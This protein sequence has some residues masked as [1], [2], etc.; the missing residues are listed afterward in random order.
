MSGRVGQSVSSSLSVVE[1]APD[2]DR[3]TSLNRT[4][5]AA[6]IVHHSPTPRYPV[7]YYTVNRKTP[8]MFLS[9]L[10]QNE[11]DSD[12]VWYMFSNVGKTKLKKYY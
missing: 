8:T 6:E 5:T 2:N 4:L 9:Y 3:V 7:P 11:A 12:K 10:L 1:S